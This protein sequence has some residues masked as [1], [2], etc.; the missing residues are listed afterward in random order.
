MT[1]K[2]PYWSIGAV[3]AGS[4]CPARQRG[5]AKSGS[6]SARGILPAGTPAEGPARYY[7]PYPASGLTAYQYLDNWPL[8]APEQI[9]F[10]GHELLADGGPPWFPQN[11]ARRRLWSEPVRA[12][13]HLMPN[14][15]RQ[16]SAPQRGYGARACLLSLLNG[17]L[18]LDG[19][20]QFV[21]RMQGWIR[22]I[23][24]GQS[25]ATLDPRDCRVHVLAD[26]SLQYADTLV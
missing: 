12:C 8:S 17:V 20:V 22:A 14:D 4:L 11:A 2:R 6:I 23:V 1:V 21:V 13:A 5:S 18:G 15:C 9:I 25:E 16:P 3:K 24:D 10:D 26:F 7:R 19:H